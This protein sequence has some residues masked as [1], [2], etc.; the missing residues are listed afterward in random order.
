MYYNARWYDSAIGRFTSADSIV[1]GGVQG[2]DRYAYS[3]NNPLRFIDPTGHVSCSGSNWDDGPQ[4]LKD[5]GHAQ[6]LL[7][8]YG[9]TL[10]NWRKA[11]AYNAYD[12]IVQI[13]GAL[14]RVTGKGSTAIFK[15]VFGPM[16]FTMDSNDSGKWHCAANA[17]GFGCTNASGKIDGRIIAHELA[18]VFRNRYFGRMG[19]T[20]DV[21]LY[22][23]IGNATITDE[24]GNYVSGVQNG[25]WERTFQGYKSNGAP[26]VYHGS[27]EW[28]DWNSTGEEFADMFM[29]W[30]Y[31]SFS[32]DN[33]GAARYKWMN[34]SMITWMKN[35]P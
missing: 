5:V 8:R 34:D 29:N 1:P 24:D 15:D 16:K 10:D 22:S 11:D 23:V 12:A 26:D 25:T 3:N 13:A 6:S 14:G 28:D 27:K 18:H 4:C 35:F 17:G 30:V 2:Y 9:I 21:D 32:A 31:D 33:A 19:K 7:S 20:T